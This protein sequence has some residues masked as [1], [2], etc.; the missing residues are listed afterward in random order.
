[1]AIRKY[2]KLLFFRFLTYLL[3]LTGILMAVVE[4]G[5]L[6]V[7]EYNFRKDQ[8]FGVKYSLPEQVITSAGATEEPSPSPS[9]SIEGGTGF[10]S[11]PESNEHLIKPVSTEFGIVIEKINANAAI[12]PDVDAGN[13][14]EYVKALT[15]GVAQ[16]KGSTNPGEN[17]NLFLFSHSTDAPWNIVRYNAIFFLLRELEVGDRVS[18]FYQGKRFDYIV[19]D[20]TIANADDISY[21]TNRYDKPVLTLQTC[22]PPGTTANRLIV[23]AKL[24]GS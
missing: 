16:A 23:R 10:G 24:I 1:M 15:K 3:I 12:I 19:Y 8:L 5:P 7:A 22:D 21:L 9:G 14:A 13:Q 17:G 4:F 11:L 2:H 6:I 20:K 18:I